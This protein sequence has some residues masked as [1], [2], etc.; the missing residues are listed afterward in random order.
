MGF[1]HAL[2]G[3][4]LARLTRDASYLCCLVLLVAQG[5][6]FGGSSSHRGTGI[7]HVVKPGENLFRIGKAYGIPY[8]ELARVNRIPDSNRIQAGHRI[9]IPGATR[10]LPVEIITPA[11]AVV[12][13]RGSRDV[14]KNRRLG[15]T[16]P[17]RGRLTSRFGPRGKSFHDGIDLAA[18]SGTPIH[19]S[20]TGRV[21]YSDELRGY[22]NLIIVRHLDGFASVYAHNQKNLAREGQR[23]SKGQVIAEVGS[24]GRVSGPHLHFEIRRNNV[25]TD[26]LYYLP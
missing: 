7:F 6:S 20:N 15:F 4:R 13:R 1:L 23:V 10:R 18:P 25:A 2:R 24:T 22:G 8:D 9:F 16:W 5:C 21:I 19:A 14:L 17:I 26:P 12:G 11:T 3:T